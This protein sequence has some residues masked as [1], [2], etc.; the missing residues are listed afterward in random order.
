LTKGVGKQPQFRQRGVFKRTAAEERAKNTELF[1]STRL[2]FILDG[3]LMLSL[4]ELK[5]AAGII[6]GRILGAKL[7]RAL[8]PEAHKLVL[9]FD[10]EA[11]RRHVV[12]SCDPESARLGLN[13]GAQAEDSRGSFNEYARAHLP[14]SV[15]ESVECSSHSRQ[16]RISLRSR[17]ADH[18]LILS[19]LGSRSNIY[20]LNAAGNVV[21]SV[22]PLEETRNELK[23]GEPWTDPPGSAPSEGVDRWEGLSDDLFLQ[24]VEETYRALELGRKAERICRRI[25]QAVRKERAFLD[26]KATNLSEDLGEA[27]QAE[28]FR[29]QGELLKSVLHTVRPG[30]D[31]VVA[32]DFSTGAVAEIPLD[33]RLSP[34]AN[35]EAYF[36]RYQKQARSVQWIERQLEELKSSQA[37]MDAVERD[38][39]GALRKVPPDIEALER[40]EVLPGVRRLVQRYS[41][42]SK[43]PSRQLQSGTKKEIPARLLPK[44]YKTRDGLE[45]WVGRNDEG[46]DY[47]TTRLAHGNDL[48]FHLE[49][50]PGSHVV[51]RTEG[52]TDP[53]PESLLDAC[54]L[55]VHFSKMKNAGS[56]D[57]HVA[58]I[59]NIKKPK[60][61]KPGL[62]Y[63]R[64]GRTVH[65]KRSPKR[66]QSILAAR[67]D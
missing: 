22:R 53:P 63:V 32:T 44:R 20:V 12:L 13:D 48:F 57:V 25:Q 66:L 15:L 38:L 17:L 37:E 50:Y 10:N 18:V 8:Q 11:G 49:G 42:K 23:P 55:A 43:P 61:A 19:I 26:R 35:L 28:K 3:D 56:A 62:V 4:R 24:A 54:E 60:G 40:I 21:H 14:G 30:D 52:R 47:L 2:P 31:R 65:L 7:K 29:Q 9:A 51:L 67:V 5:R 58:P 33:P 36:E 34:A 27:V 45:I 46:N 39:E 1:D 16:V 64:S 41:P 59:K 6:Q